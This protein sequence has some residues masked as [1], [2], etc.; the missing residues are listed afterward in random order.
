MEKVLPLWFIRHPIRDFL[1]P[2]F[3]GAFHAAQFQ[4]IAGVDRLKSLEKEFLL[5]T[6]IMRMGAYD[7]ETVSAYQSFWLAIEPRR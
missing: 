7:I 5:Y 3:A 6:K 1:E 4:M 2:R